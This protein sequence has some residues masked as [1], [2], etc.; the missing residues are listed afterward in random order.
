MS[1]NSANTQ[2]ITIKN[3][4][5][6]SSLTQIDNEDY[7]KLEQIINDIKSCQDATN[8]LYPVDVKIFTDYLKAINDR[9]MDIST[10]ITK[11]SQ[12]RYHFIQDVYDD[13]Q[14]IWDN[15]RI[16][17]KEGFEIYNQAERMEKICLEIFSKYYHVQKSETKN[18]VKEF[19]NNVY[20]E[21]AFND[22]NYYKDN[23][24]FVD[25]YYK[26]IRE[27]VHLLRLIKSLNKE[28]IQ[29]LITNCSDLKPFITVNEKNNFNLHI[30]CMDSENL[31]K[32]ES[33]INKVK[34]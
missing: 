13:F 10:I 28:Q 27:K 6:K 23:L 19:D 2:F 7:K 21:E 17:N 9:P 5:L 25:P 8:F 20:D 15:C 24:G 33:E 34:Q 31:S 18:F 4:S 30:E 1:T 11:L 26:N 12:K 3:E 22:P 14:L 29:Q 16:Y 32:I